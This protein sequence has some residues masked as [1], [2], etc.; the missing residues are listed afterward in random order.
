M[1]LE[2]I[3]LTEEDLTA[4]GVNSSWLPVVRAAVLIV[5]SGLWEDRIGSTGGDF[6]AA[7]GAVARLLRRIRYPSIA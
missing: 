3:A 2:Y 1:V 6:F 5:L 4:S 7:N